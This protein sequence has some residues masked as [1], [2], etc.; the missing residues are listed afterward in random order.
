MV[1]QHQW[2][3]KLFGF[4]F[5][6]EYRPGR[7]NTAA[8]AFSRRDSEAASEEGGTAATAA[9]AALSRPSFTYLDDVHCATATAPDT[10]LLQERF[11]AGEL[12][13]PWCEDAGLLLHGSRIFVPDFGDLRHQAIQLAHGAGH[14]GIQKTLHRLCSDFYIL[15]D[16]T[17]VQDWVRTCATCQCNKTEAL[18]PAGLLQPLDVP[19]QVWADISM[20]FIEGLPKVGSKSVI[21]TVVDRFSKYAHFIVLGHP[22][23][24]ASVASAFF[25]GIVRLHGFPTSIVSDRDP[26]FTGHVW[27]DLFTMAGVKLRMSTTFHPQTDG[28]SEVVNKVIAMFL[29]CVTGD[30]PRAWVD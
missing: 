30:R 1:P 18:Q 27:H 22:Y 11:C 29:H 13:A 26:V 28:Q 3:S 2:V 15:G 19:S 24:A 6:V 5:V 4:D 12:V 25:D 16:R 10:L 20:D 23:T 14:K 8:D 7:L 21:L 17:L 9:V